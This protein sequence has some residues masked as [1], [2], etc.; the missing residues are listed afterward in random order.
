MSLDEKNES[1]NSTENK[2]NITLS[3]SLDITDINNSIN[4]PTETDL[5]NDPESAIETTYN[6][7]KE[8]ISQ[9]NIKESNENNTKKNLNLLYGNHIS[10]LQPKYLGK[11]RALFYRNDY[12]LI[13]IGPDCKLN[14]NNIIKIVL[15]FALYQHLY[16]FIFLNFLF[17]SRIIISLLKFL[18]Q[19]SFLFLH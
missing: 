16:V 18:K 15:V 9:I 3:T 12:P 10:N 1:S 6:V 17:F 4:A 19:C 7:Q 14:I 8:K 11:T 5:L 2:S 13:I